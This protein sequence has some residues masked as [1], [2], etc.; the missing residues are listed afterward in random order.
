M[1]MILIVL[2][3]FPQGGACSK[4]HEHDHDQEQE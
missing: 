1:L 2:L 4:D 3:I